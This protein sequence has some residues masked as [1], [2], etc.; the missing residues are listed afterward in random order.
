[1]SIIDYK[2]GVTFLESSLS[3]PHPLFTLSLS[4]SLSLSRSLSLPLPLP[5]SLSVHGLIYSLCPIWLLC[6]ASY[7][8]TSLAYHILW[9]QPVDM[10]AVNNV[11]ILTVNSFS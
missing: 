6:Y 9:Q 5:L 8:L 11:N 1:M 3:L 4:L 2:K 10:H 7:M